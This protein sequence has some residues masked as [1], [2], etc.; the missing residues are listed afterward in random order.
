MDSDEELQIQ[1]YD[2][3]D[4][5]AASS[6]DMRSSGIKMTPKVP[7]QFDGQSSWFEYEDLID[8]WLGITTLDPEKHCPSLKN[9]LAR[10]ASC[11]KSM[12]DYILLRDA[13]R[14]PSHFKDTLRHYFV[15]GVNHVF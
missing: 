5:F 14:G 8:D 9:A 2:E 11:H 15:E 13:D 7:P 4:A 1:T 6:S 12:L 3:S 10:A